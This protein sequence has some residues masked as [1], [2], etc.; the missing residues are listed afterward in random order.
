MHGSHCCSSDPQV[1]E[2][3]FRCNVIFLSYHIPIKFTYNKKWWNLEFYK[4]RKAKEIS[5]AKRI[6]LANFKTVFFY[7]CESWKCT[8]NIF[9]ICKPL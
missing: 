1:F 9:Q 5:I 6:S 7:G 8:M 2:K 3:G 4:T